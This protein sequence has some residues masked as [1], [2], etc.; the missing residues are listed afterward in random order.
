M[1]RLIGLLVM[2]LV[3]PLLAQQPTAQQGQP[4]TRLNVLYANGVAGSGLTLNVGGGTSFCGATINQYPAGTLTMTASAENYVYLNL[5]S[6]CAPQVKTTPFVAGDI[7]IA[8][9]QT[10]ATVILTITDVRTPFIAGQGLPALSNPLGTK[11]QTFT[12]PYTP[13]DTPVYDGSGDLIDSGFAPQAPVYTELVV[14]SFPVTGCTVGGVT[15]TNQL[16][17]A[18]YTA[19]SEITATHGVRLRLGSKL[20]YIETALVEPVCTVNQGPTVDLIGLGHEHSIIELTNDI[21]TSGNAM[22]QFQDSTVAYNFC[23]THMEGFKL[24][25]NNYAVMAANYVALD[26]SIIRDV[27]YASNVYPG[28]TAVVNVGDN[29]TDV[30]GL[31]LGETYEMNFEKSAIDSY[32]ASIQAQFNVTVSN[33]IPSATVVVAGSGYDTRATPYLTGYGAGSQPC[34]TM[35]TITPTIVNTG[36]TALTFTGY[37]GCSGPLWVN[38]PNA[39]NVSYAYQFQHMTDSIV[40]DFVAGAGNVCEFYSATKAGNNTYIG[41]HPE[42]AGLPCG[43]MESGGSDVFISTELDTVGHFGFIF[44]STTTNRSVSLIGTRHYWNSQVLGGSSDY[45]IATTGWGSINISNDVCVNTISPTV[46]YHSVVTTTGPIQLYSGEVGSGLIPSFL[47]MTNTMSCDG[48]N[49]VRPLTASSLN[50]GDQAGGLQQFL[51]GVGQQRGYLAYDYRGVAPVIVGAG[52]GHPLMF[53]SNTIPFS[54]I[55]SGTFDVNGIFGVGT[56]TNGLLDPF[57]VTQQG[58]VTATKVQ[59]AINDMGGYCYNVT[60]YGL[61]GDGVTDNTA[62][63]STM[64][65]TVLPQVYMSTDGGSI[66]A[67]AGCITWPQGNFHF[68]TEITIPTG[69]H[70]LFKGTGTCYENATHGS[71]SASPTGCTLISSSDPNGILSA[72]TGGTQP[73]STFWAQ[74]MDFRED[75]TMAH[76]SNAIYLNGVAWGGLERVGVIND[77]SISGLACQDGF[78]VYANVGNNSG[79]T[80]NHIQIGAFASSSTRYNLYIGGSDWQTDDIFIN[81]NGCSLNAIQVANYG[82]RSSMGS[83]HLNGIGNGT[84]QIQLIQLQPAATGITDNRTLTIPQLALDTIVS[85]ASQTDDWFIRNDTLSRIQIGRVFTG[86]AINCTQNFFILNSGWISAKQFDGECSHTN[87]LIDDAVANGLT[88]NTN[89]AGFSVSLHAD[90]VNPGQLN[91]GTTNTPGVASGNISFSH[92]LAYGATPTIAAGPAAGNVPNPSV[93]TA[94]D[95]DGQIN[96]ST[97]TGTLPANAVLVTITFGAPWSV[98]PHCTLTPKNAATALVMTDI[99]I[100]ETTTTFVIN[101]GATPLQT[102]FSA[103]AWDYTCAQ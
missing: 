95:S 70:I 31:P 12:G 54:S 59:A 35:G 40:S 32:N 49:L 66:T 74:D 71:T 72:P 58:A 56:S 87:Y 15:Y 28:S 98:A 50:I 90:P 21:H 63:F 86:P 93:A 27:Y 73:T 19:A 94:H 89:G 13:G 44:N 99:F 76:S 6:S 22:L 14:D 52:S 42:G 88:L 38:M 20:Y 5:S 7:P 92:Y 85:P 57:H 48:S 43:V 60:A 37:A 8:E 97:G 16:T 103:Y 77:P 30:N 36:V 24:E 46:G 45:Y 47:T 84:A 100:T 17:C 1:K 3:T 25:P 26:R 96:V 68:A 82:A 23:S 18:F 9:V 78:G 11:L 39:S 2:L 41:L 67:P 62:A 4:L 33:G 69:S 79:L 61:V 53:Q 83:L 102:N 65:S 64:L 91:V 51:I 80:L 10:S 101:V 55:Y 29:N 81:G 34:T 75:G